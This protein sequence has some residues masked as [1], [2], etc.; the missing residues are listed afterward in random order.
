MHRALVLFPLG[1]EVRQFGHSGVL[2]KLLDDGW[3]V[4]IAAKVVDDDLRNQLDARVRIVP[5]P[6]SKLS[7]VYHRV[8]AVLDR[9]HALKERKLGKTGWQYKTIAAK[10]WKENLIFRFE[11][12]AALFAAASPTLFRLGR[13]YELQ[14]LSKL[15]TPE[16][17]SL[18]SEVRPDV[19]LLNIPQAK[20]FHPLLHVAR[21]GGIGTALLYHTWKDVAAAGRLSSVFDRLGVWSAAMRDEL[22]RQNPWLDPEAV[23]IVGCTHFDCVG[24]NDLL[25]PEPELRDSIGVNRGSPLLLYV[26]SAP[27]LIPG[28][29]RFVRLLSRAIQEGKLPKATQIV[30]RTNPMDNTGSLEMA[31]RA[32]WPQVVVSKPNWRWDSSVNWCFQRREDLLLYNSLLKYAS[33]CVGVPSTV[34]VECAIA[35]LPTVNIGFELTGQPQPAISV[36]TFWDADFYREVRTTRAAQLA[37][38]PE[39]MV[40]QITL[41]MRDRS[42]GSENRRALV[43]AQLGV[44]P[45]F[46][47]SSAFEFLKQLVTESERGKGGP[48]PFE[49]LMRPPGTPKQHSNR[50][51]R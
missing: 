37:N 39:E 4:T 43:S 21:Q 18:L 28:E 15:L 17:A 46:A 27:W 51:R 5:Q 20:A 8:S 3:N 32:D 26:A 2:A 22:L 1:S 36:R 14:L 50:L 34:T 19:I 12:L 40:D 29:E 6:K 35:D 24:R 23:Q 31:L 44:P 33:V 25:L 45:H 16:W 47:A 49:Y 9:A 42:I 13:D 11:D 41:T 10:N 30:M 38:S 48:G 7:F